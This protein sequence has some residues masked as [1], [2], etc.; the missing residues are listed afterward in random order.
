MGKENVE[1]EIQEQVHPKSKV[2]RFKTDPE[3]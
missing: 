3:E 1:A 2:N